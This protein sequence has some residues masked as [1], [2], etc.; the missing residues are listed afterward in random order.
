MLNPGDGKGLES[1]RL[2][3]VVGKAG[4]IL[5]CEAP[6]SQKRI[7]SFVEIKMA[8]DRTRCH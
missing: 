3:R 7:M 8:V 2:S 1:E 6:V 5:N 4:W